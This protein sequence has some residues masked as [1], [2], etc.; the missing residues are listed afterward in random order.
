MPTPGKLEV[1]IKINQLPI[2][3]TT[4]SNGWKEFSLDCGGRLVTVA[5]RPRMWNKLEEAQKS[6]PLWVAAI[7]GQ[8]GPAHGKGFALL[9]PNLQV[10]ERKAKPS[11][12]EAG[13][14]AGA[15]PEGAKED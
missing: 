1:I 12:E 11:A 7:S 5:L 8:M 2:E 4:K 9:E 13:P 3:V 15:P 14:P 10:F 6:F